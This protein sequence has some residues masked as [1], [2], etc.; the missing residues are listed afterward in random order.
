[1][2]ERRNINISQIITVSNYGGDARLYLEN[3]I[4]A[5]GARFTRAMKTENTHL[6]TARDTSDKCAAAREWGIEMVNHLWLEETYARCQIQPISNLKYTTFPKRT[7]LMEVVGQTRVD[8]PVMQELYWEDMTEDVDMT[9]APDTS[10]TTNVTTDTV[11]PSSG[12]PEPTS[13][14]SEVTPRPEKTKT[15]TKAKALHETPSRIARLS[16]PV[17]VMSSGSRRA[18]DNANI[19]LH[20][21]IMPDVMNYEK[22][23][24]RKG[25]VLGAGRKRS[26]TPTNDKE[27]D[28]NAKRRGMSADVEPE[29]SDTSEDETTTKDKTKK[30]KKKVPISV[31]LLLTAHQP[32][33]D[34]PNREEG[35]KVCPISPFFIF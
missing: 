10:R 35:D 19:K 2:K 3:L 9:D 1:M 34:T 29:N 32:W 12:A 22:E 25:G 15:K 8:L 5:C 17:S 14:M 27:S 7:N 23:K 11:G 21:E 20:N 31:F 24:K 18:K 13:S 26:L 4:E 16:S 28:R 30:S 6:I 33:L